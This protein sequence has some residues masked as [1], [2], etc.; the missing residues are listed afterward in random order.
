MKELAI[1]QIEWL[2]EMRNDLDFD[3]MEGPPGE[4]LI[5]RADH[6]GGPWSEKWLHFTVSFLELEYVD[7]ETR[8]NRKAEEGQKRP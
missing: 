2:Y 6:M 1:K 8:E 7:A 3:A 4:Y 5:R